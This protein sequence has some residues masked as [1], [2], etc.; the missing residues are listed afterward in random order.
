MLQ[1]VRIGYLPPM[2]H[3]NLEMPISDAQV[4]ALRAGDT[5]TLQRTLYGIRD[6]TQI[7]MFDR[8]RSTAFDMRG[9]AVVHTAPNV[10]KVP[11]S[12]AYPA[13]YEALCVGTTTSSRMERFSAPLLSQ[14]GVRLIVGK[15]GMQQASL[16]AF[17]QFGGAYL[18]VVG[19]AAA[20]QTSW[21]E[22]IEAV[23]MDDLNPESLWRFRI[24]D[25]GPLLVGM[26]SHG[27]SLYNTVN[28]EVAQRR[29]AVLAKLGVKG[30]TSGP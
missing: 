9:H 21:I 28:D 8:G 15:G 23:D 11:V 7:A 4:R 25:F 19:G 27:G 18:A 16:A 14:Y 13:G 24:R 17:A 2:A 1:E 20:L 10:R 12:D 29:A 22:A 3:H 30:M 6:A 5:V 26:D